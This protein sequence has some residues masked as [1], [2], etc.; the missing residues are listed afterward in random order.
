MRS[1]RC[2]AIFSICRPS[3]DDRTVGTFASPSSSLA[4]GKI[5]PGCLPYHS[6]VATGTTPSASSASCSRR[7]ATTTRLGSDLIV[8][9]PYLWA[10]VTG[11]A[12]SSAFVAL[13]E[14][15]EEESSS[16]ELPQAVSAKT[17]IVKIRQR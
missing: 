2:A 12:P 11:K 3:V 15:F 8:V 10:M 4:H 9:A 17:E 14:D 6:V 1:G 13:A 7:P 5:A 16:E